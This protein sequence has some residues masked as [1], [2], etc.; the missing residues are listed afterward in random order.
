MPPV[1]N[2]PASPPKKRSSRK[3][4]AQPSSETPYSS[5]IDP[6]QRAMLIAKAAYYRALRRGFAPGH[7]TQDWLAAEAEVDTELMSGTT[8]SARI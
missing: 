8:K 4:A 1:K 7:E 3:R 6:Q 2:P 5:F